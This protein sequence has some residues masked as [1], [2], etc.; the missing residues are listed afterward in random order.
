MKRKLI[1]LCALLLVAVMAVPMVASAATYMYVK[2]S[3]GINLN[4]H[5]EPVLTKSNVVGSVS[6]R[7]RVKVVDYVNSN[8]ALVEPDGW[9]NPYY[10]LRSCLSSKD[11]GPYTE[12]TTV[13]VQYDY[14]KLK[15]VDPYYVT[16]TTGKGG[17]VANLRWAPNKGSALMEKITPGSQVKV[18]AKG[19]Y[20]YQVMDESN[21]YIGFLYYTFIDE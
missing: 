9:S 20:W 2:T 12:P 6:Y 5:S 10:C 21:D 14:S 11:P 8:W 17:G 4:M 15:H 7:T 16:V 19:G 1:A 18:L 13:Y 3:N